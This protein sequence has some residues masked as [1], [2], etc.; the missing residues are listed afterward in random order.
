MVGCGE[1]DHQDI[2]AQSVWGYPAGGVW[3]QI[4]ERAIRTK[5]ALDNPGDGEYML[6]DAPFD[7]DGQPFDNPPAGGDLYQYDSGNSRWIRRNRGV[8]IHS[9]GFIAPSE[10]NAYWFEN[11]Y[12]ALQNGQTHYADDLT[13]NDAMPA[14]AGRID[15]DGAILWHASHLFAV[16]EQ[17]QSSVSYT[18]LTLPTKA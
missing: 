1:P 12:P 18:H 17:W 13:D 10:G 6:I 16:T 11:G 14:L 3:A 2:P 9:N 8:N 7:Q 15:Y 5:R 4:T